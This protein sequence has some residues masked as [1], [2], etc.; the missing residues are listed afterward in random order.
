MEVSDFIQDVK[1]IRM[2]LITILYP[3]RN[4]EVQRIKR[5]LDSLVQQSEKNFVVKFIDYGSDAEI[6]KEIRALVSEYDF[7][8][9]EYL[10]TKNQLWNKSKALN[11]AIKRIITDYCFVA[12]VD[13]IFHSEFTQILEKQLDS[14][15]ITYFQVG[16]LSEQ[17]T[18]KETSFENYKVNFKSNEEATGM[19]LF[20]VVALKEING[21]DEFFHFWGAED[22]DVHNRLKQAGYRVKYY[23]EKLLMLHQWHPNYR[24]RETKTLNAIELQLSGAVE[25]NHQHLLDNL[26]NNVT[27][28]NRDD[29]GNIMSEETREE[30]EAFP[31]TTLLDEKKQIDY[32][33]YQQLPN[34]K[35]K[36]IAI[37]IKETPEQYSLKYKIK[38]A[39]GKKVSKFY[40]R[41][42]INDQILLHIIAFYHTKPYIYQVKEKSILFK[43]KT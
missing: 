8:S 32:F 19:T 4:R 23:D 14:H 13:M 41:K 22:T 18:R 3:Y 5:S 7:A 2:N 28:V 25:I 15:W 31:V 9:Y 6:A 34:A 37:E 11:F 16:F 36:I 33:L 17:E 29:W 39:L 21:F 1:K 26:K 12:D 24:K 40:N 30:L 20:P 35:N 43:I 42:E 10:N 38:K 27:K